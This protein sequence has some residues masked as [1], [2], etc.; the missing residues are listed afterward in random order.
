VAFP[1]Y[2]W[3]ARC[4]PGTSHPHAEPSPEGE[5]ITSFT[6]I[7]TEA[8][9][10]VARLHHRMPVILTPALEDAWLDTSLTDSRHISDMLDQNAGVSLDAYPVS[11]RVN[12]ARDDDP[13]L[14]E[15]A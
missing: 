9:G 4:S 14:I 2:Q 13:A 6:I 3:S 10:V 15:P 12:A 11:R 5:E 8:Q 7:T 1:R